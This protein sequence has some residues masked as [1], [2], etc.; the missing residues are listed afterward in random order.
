MIVVCLVAF[1]FGFIGS[2]PMAGPIAVMVVS[3]AAK[4]EHAG[5]VRVAFGAAIAEGFYAGF[6]FWGFATF[7]ASHPRVLPWSHGLTALVLVGLG[8]R[9][10]VWKQKREEK[11]GERPS[12]ADMTKSFVTGLGITALNP[13]LLVTWSAAVTALHSR[14]WVKMTPWLAPPFGLFAALGVAAWFA[15]LVALMRRYEKHFNQ[16][17]LTWIVRGMGL[18]LIGLGVASG[19]SFVR[20][21]RGEP[22]KSAASGDVSPSRTPPSAAARS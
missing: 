4:A 10:V 8:V 19:V 22:A 1:V 2:M 5:A 7:L 12:M 16:N 21:L 18:L 14:Q 13:T 3:R 15:I 17:V 6:A 9:F 20:Y 11:S